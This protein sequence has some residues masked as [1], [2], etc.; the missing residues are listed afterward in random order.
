MLY[1]IINTDLEVLAFLENYADVITIHHRKDGG[2]DIDVKSMTFHNDP[3]NYPR[4]KNYLRRNGFTSIVGV[5]TRPQVMTEV[6]GKDFVVKHIPSEDWT[7]SIVEKVRENDPT[8]SVEDILSNVNKA[9]ESY[10][11]GR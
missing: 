6:M 11:K 8:A 3:S 10:V 9:Y 1:K 7:N 4:I 2:L 5:H